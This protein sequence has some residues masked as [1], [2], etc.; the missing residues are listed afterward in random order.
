MIII[1]EGMY[2][3]A[4]SRPPSCGWSPPPQQGQLRTHGQRK[5][6]GE[7]GRETQLEMANNRSRALAINGIMTHT[8]VQLFPEPRLHKTPWSHILWLLLTPD[9]LWTK[10]Q[11]D[12]H[13]ATMKPSN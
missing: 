1:G 7:K 9:E 2:L 3:P 5:R 4:I 13:S 12:E 8:A 6:A 11:L 10:R